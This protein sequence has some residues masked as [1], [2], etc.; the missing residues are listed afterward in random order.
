MAVM[1]EVLEV[2]VFARK[3]VTREVI[4]GEVVT[5]EVMVLVVGM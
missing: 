1:V 2:M 4:L 3:L 5:V